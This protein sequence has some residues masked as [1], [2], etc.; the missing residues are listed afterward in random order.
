MREGRLVERWVWMAANPGAVGQQWEIRQIDSEE[1]F[2]HRLLPL[3]RPG[4]A[5]TLRELIA[6]HGSDDLYYVISSP[7]KRLLMF[8]PLEDLRPDDKPFWAIPV[9]SFRS[10]LAKAWRSIYDDDAYEYVG[11]DEGIVSVTAR[12]NV[13]GRLATQLR[14]RVNAGE[15]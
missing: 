8:R 2:R 5:R 7:P 11:D 10:A 4:Y 15:R 6:E 3:L 14:A 9:D 12:N 1:S 13:A